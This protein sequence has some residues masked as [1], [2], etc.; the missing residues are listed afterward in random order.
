MKSLVNID[1]GEILAQS[2]NEEYLLTI[3]FYIK[4]E[5]EDINIW[6]L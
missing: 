3:A 6:I 4:R 2:Y 1:T 5:S